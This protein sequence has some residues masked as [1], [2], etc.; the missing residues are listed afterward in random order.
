ME[1]NYIEVFEKAITEN[2]KIIFLAGDLFHKV[3]YLN[4]EEL[5]AAMRF[6]M[7][8]FGIA[9]KRSIYLRILRGTF[10]HDNRQ[11]NTL[12]PIAEQFGALKGT[13]LIKIV[14]SIEVEELCDLTVLYKPDNCGFKDAYSV[15]REKLDLLNIS[16]VDLFVNHGYLAP[17]IPAGL[18][19]EPENSFTV[20]ELNSFVKG[21]TLNGHIHERIEL[22]HILNSGC[23]ESSRFDEMGEKGISRVTYDRTTCAYTTDFIINTNSTIFEE[24]ILPENTTWEECKDTVLVFRDMLLQKKTRNNTIHIR[25]RTDDKELFMACRELFMVK[26]RFRV[27]HIHRTKNVKEYKLTIQQIKLKNIITEDNF[28]EHVAKTL[29]DRTIS[30]TFIKEVITKQQ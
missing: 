18:P 15:I 20:E 25:V 21:I 26:G 27:K 14:T 2:T 6:I 23:V 24:L 5:E 4:T 12:I 1:K 9:K 3:T 8:L 11:L 19:I 16:K 28:V 29:N 13:P 17:L 10:T 22:P 7:Y 30:T